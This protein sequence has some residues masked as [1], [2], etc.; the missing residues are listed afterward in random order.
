M[1]KDYHSYE[2]VERGGQY[3]AYDRETEQRALNPETP[4][5]EQKHI[6]HVSTTT[7]LDVDPDDLEKPDVPLERNHWRL[8]TS[9]LVHILPTA[10]TIAV[11]QLTIRQ[12]YWFDNDAD[13]TTIPW[14][15]AKISVT[16]LNNLLQFV[17]KIHE[18]LLVGSLAAMVMHRVRVR[19]IGKSGLPFGILVGGYQVGSPEYL[20]SAAFRSG[21]NRKFWPL[22]LLI[23]VFTV[24][25]NTLGPVSAV[26][27]VPNLDWYDMKNPFGS[28]TLPIL[29]NLTKN[30]IWP[31]EIT[32]F[33]TFHESEEFC[34]S[35]G[36]STTM[37]CPASGFTDLMFWTASNANEAIDVS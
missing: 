24:L 5:A 25:A 20:L 30:D 13:S 36:V 32:K 16:E 35:P 18:I 37:A 6:P 1:S 2:L 7:A 31:L 19:L 22:S 14:K 21:F 12:V 26:A 9:N 23:F 28:E 15:G 27:L 34:F 4:L 3:T 11:V 10:A 8:V 17:A 33:H 29:F